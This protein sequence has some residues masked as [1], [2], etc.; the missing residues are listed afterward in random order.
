MSQRDVSGGFKLAEQSKAGD[1]GNGQ[2]IQ[3]VTA[4]Y[5]KGAFFR[6]IHADGVI[7]GPTPQGHMHIVFYSERPPLPRRLVQPIT[8]TGQLGPPIPEKSVIRDTTVVREMDIDVIMTYAVAQSLY[9][10]LGANLE[11]FRKASGE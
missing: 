11:Q 7:G 5:I 4:D 9:Q 1:G 10:W 3:E 2:L 6:V 8:S